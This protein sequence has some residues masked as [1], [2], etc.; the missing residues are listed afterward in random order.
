MKDPID[1]HKGET[2]APVVAIMGHIDHGKSTLLDFIRKTNVVEGEAGG[3]TQHVSAYEVEHIKEDGTKAKITFLD[4]PGH[5]AFKGIRSRGA[6]VADIAVLVVSAED[7]VKPQTLEAYSKIKEAGLPFIVAVTKIDKPGANIEAVKQSLAE[8]GL[9][10]EGYGGDVPIILTSAKTGAG[11]KELLDMIILMADLEHFVGHLER[12]GTG[13]I[14]ESKLDPKRGIT[15][16]GIIK[17]GTVKKGM[18]AASVGAI[19]PLRFILDAEGNEQESLSFSSPIQ[20]VGW[21]SMPPVGATFELFE[22]KKA[23]EFYAESEAGKSA[24]GKKN[25]KID[26]NMFTLPII[27]KADVSGS[28]EAIVYEINKLSRERIVP[29]IVIEGVGTVGENDIHSA[30]TMPGTIIFAFHTKIDPQARAL[31]ERS[32]VI[33]ESFDIIYKLTERISELLN[34]RKPRIEVE[35]ISGTAKV[36]K[37]FNATKDKQVLGAR[38]TSGLIKVGGQVRIVRRET[39]IGKGVIK[40]LQQNKIGI[41]KISEGDEFGAMIESKIEIAPGDV[42]E[43]IIKVTK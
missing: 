28:L 10:V 11:V 36:L 33:I 43:E 42:L 23:A 5:E 31:A 13:V 17:D 24:R 3:I 38:V 4:T 18:T 40:E 20:I 12:W 22:N 30:M 9:Y 25:Q 19:A 37:I 27:I 26:E 32:G 2:R 21:D 14:I 7:A 6:S 35:E 34:E 8:N 16:V 1:I 39:E 41:D 15:T 29:Q